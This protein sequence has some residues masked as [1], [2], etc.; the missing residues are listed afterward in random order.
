M[1]GW[2]V[3]R[4]SVLP[5]DPELL[6]ELLSGGNQQK[7]VVSRWMTCQRSVF[8]FD[9]PTE[10]VDAGAREIIYD[11]IDECCGAGAAV[12]LL[13][14][15][16]D[17]VVQICDRAL[18]L[19]DGAIEAELSGEDLTVRHLDELLLL[20]ETAEPGATGDVGRAG[21]SGEGESRG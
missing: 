15:D 7:V 6:I 19:S 16:I 5:S 21:E 13:S 14:S 9:E 18:F 1:A 17:E 10:G 2:L 3:E 11:F 4:Y 20:R 8:V 12:L